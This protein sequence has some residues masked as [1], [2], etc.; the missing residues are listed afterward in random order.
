MAHNTMSRAA[1]VAA[2][3]PVTVHKTVDLAFNGLFAVQGGVPLRNALDGLSTLLSTAREAAY[4]AA[5]T[6][7]STDST[8]TAWAVEHLL[9]M[10]YALNESISLGLLQHQADGGEAGGAKP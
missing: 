10:A 5:S 3:G 6:D 4:Q 7:G 8:G 2:A 1:G 9:T